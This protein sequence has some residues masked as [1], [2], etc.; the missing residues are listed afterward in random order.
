MKHCNMNVNFFFRLL[1]HKQFDK[2]TKTQVTTE[3]EGNRKA[4]KRTEFK[5]TGDND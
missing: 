3:I 5:E 2:A 4:N 1:H